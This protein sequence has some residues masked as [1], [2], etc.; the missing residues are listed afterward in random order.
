MVSYIDLKNGDTL[1]AGDEYS[2]GSNWRTIPDFMVGDTIPN[3]ATH[4]RRE[5]I[6]I[7]NAPPKRRLFSLFFDKHK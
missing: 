4:W 6:D 3:S 2:T 5:V 7:K 1:K